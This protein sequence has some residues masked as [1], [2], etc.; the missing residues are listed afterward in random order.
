MGGVSIGLRISEISPN[1]STGLTCITHGRFYF[2]LLGQSKKLEIK[3]RLG[4][5]SKYVS[6]WNRDLGNEIGICLLLF[7]GSNKMTIE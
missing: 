1:V 4:S 7:W 2:L 5:S 6:D 3:L